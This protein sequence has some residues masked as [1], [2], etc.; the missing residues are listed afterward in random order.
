[1]AN[2]NALCSNS[3]DPLA[4]T[5]PAKAKD[6]GKD[7]DK[8]KDKDK[9]KGKGAT[10]SA[11]K[12]GAEK[13]NEELDIEEG[14]FAAIPKNLLFR[15]L[16]LVPQATNMRMAIVAKLWQ[17]ESAHVMKEI[18]SLD[19]RGSYPQLDESQLK[20]L[21]TKRVP[22]E[23]LTEC[24]L[25]S[26]PHLTDKCL[27][28]IAD[29]CPN[30]TTLNIS[31]SANITSEGL[32]FIGSKL[33]KLASLD[34]SHTPITE[35]GL[36]ALGKIGATLTTLSLAD[37]YLVSDR[38]LE[39]LTIFPNLEVLDISRCA[40][41]DDTCITAL[42][43]LKRLRHLSMTWM[44]QM[45]PHGIARLCNNTTTSSSNTPADVGSTLSG[46]ADGPSTAPNGSGD[47][48]TGSMSSGK[49]F[50][51]TTTA[52]TTSA[53]N[54]IGFFQSLQYLDLT[55]NEMT[56]ASIVGVCKRFTH[57]RTLKVGWCDITDDA[58]ADGIKSLERLERLCIE[59]TRVTQRGLR[60]LS[61]L[62][63]L[64][65]VLIYGTEIS[66]KSRV[67]FVTKNP[68]VTVVQHFPG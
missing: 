9:A 45:T 24:H 17:Q 22:A 55:G 60:Q 6:K 41:I 63:K 13:E 29:H 27:K 67:T 68:H 30:L 3:A 35:K 53:T 37:G 44:K 32:K 12:K 59:Y 16:G 56:N 31:Q 28:L 18:T 46:E 7:K 26:F 58:I 10:K 52:T 54:E 38:S 33:T 48:Q 50:K 43:Q 19:L 66:K 61:H 57:L 62:P 1:V 14:P 8:N 4:T 11:D 47:T 49:E 2:T 51:P 65:Y 42:Q 39:A 36:R 64:S 20:L 15:I 25:V 5:T 23:K 21:L 34:V 40:Q